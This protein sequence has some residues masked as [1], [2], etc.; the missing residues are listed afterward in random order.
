MTST[1]PPP[2]ALRRLTRLQSGTIPPVNYR[3]LTATSSVA[4]PVPSN[5]HSALAVPNWR[6]AMADEYRALMDNG[7]WRL[8]P[9]PPGVNIVFGWW[10]WKLKY[11]AGGT[12]S[13]HKARWV[14]RGYNQK[15]GVDY[16]ETFSP[17]VDEGPD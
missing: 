9:R 16:D 3:N 14:A 15:P 8:V 11:N 5:Y 2:A 4:S 17:V 7:T 1:N 13:K 6:A 12:L 10:L